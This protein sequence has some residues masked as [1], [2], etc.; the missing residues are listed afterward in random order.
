MGSKHITRSGTRAVSTATAEPDVIT[1]KA[2]ITLLTRNDFLT[3]NRVPMLP[4]CALI[5]DQLANA[6][7]T[8]QAE[9]LKSGIKAMAVILR[10]ISTC[11][12]AETALE[13]M[14][15]MK[16]NIKEELLAEV[17]ESA[18]LGA[19]EQIDSLHAY[20]DD[21]SKEIRDSFENSLKIFG[22]GTNLIQLPSFEEGEVQH[23]EDQ[24]TPSKPTTYA[25]VHQKANPNVDQNLHYAAI[26]QTNRLESQVVI[27]SDPALDFNSLA[28]L[29]MDDVVAKANTAIESVAS[30]DISCP[31]NTKIVGAKRTKGGAIVLHP[32]NPSTGKWLRQVKVIESV[33]AE[34]TTAV[35]RPV[36]LE[37]M[38]KFVSIDFITTDQEFLRAVE[39]DNGIDEHEIRSARWK[40]PV[41]NRH[42]GQKVAFLVLGFA[43]ARSVLQCNVDV[44]FILFFSSLLSDGVQ[45]PVLITLQASP[46]FVSFTYAYL[47]LIEHCLVFA[48]LSDSSSTWRLRGF[49][50]SD[51]YTTWQLQGYSLL[52]TIYTSTCR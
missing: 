48:Y 7:T 44:T 40:K 25:N 30:R 20:W 10:H 52:S 13:L 41:K 1:L 28:N 32:N 43:T 11:N 31:T 4:E 6:K 22:R 17:S 35:I 33:N 5:L 49:I 38:V 15:E 24:H 26:D 42:E 51:S 23:F 18:L 50:Y 12:V 19:H 14:R 27:M 21:R 37:V 29:S 45:P 34:L 2:A 16:D 8:G 39:R 46:C 9:A 36:V 47:S 3:E